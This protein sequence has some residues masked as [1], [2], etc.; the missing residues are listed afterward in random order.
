[1][2]A[3]LSTVWVYRYAVRRDI[4]D[5]PN[6]RSSHQSPAP[7]GGGLAIVFSYVGA[8]ISSVL[9]GWVESSDF[10]ALCIGGLAVAAV[11][12]WDDHGHVS[13]WFR[14]SAHILAAFWAVHWIGGIL[15]VQFGETILDLGPIGDIL[16]A[17]S[18]VWLLNL[19]NFMDGI[20][21]IAGVEAAI[22]AGG[23]AAILLF[24]GGQG[25]KAAWLLL[26]VASVLGF[27]V[28]NWPPAR[29][30]MGDVG[31][32][33][34]GYV[35]GVAA[36]VTSQTGVL[37]IWSWVIL[38]AVFVGDATFTLLRRMARGDRWYRA[39]R[40]H[41]YQILSRRWRSH[42]KVTLVVGIYDLIWLIPLA[43]AA[44]AYPEWSLGFVLLAYAPVLIIAYYLGAGVP[45]N[46][47]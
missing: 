2:V 18:I 47:T 27:I 12:L 14:F 29:I 22:V 20:D 26:L 24:F 17:L 10:I 21:G 35:L 30:F 46:S 8:G 31:S 16:A 6:E 44:T 15:P 9:L 3:F 39:H 25:Q 5:H 38:L 32:G 34:L 4:L 41:A 43:M 23:G 1:M 33:F 13:Q 36:L 28:W 7:R 19:Y 37:T 42:L 45:K 11:G 40:I